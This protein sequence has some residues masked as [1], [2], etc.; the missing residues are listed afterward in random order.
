MP[1]GLRAWRW[2]NVTLLRLSR[3]DVT[4]LRSGLAMVT[5]AG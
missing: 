5:P 4:L 3:S 2:S 1:I